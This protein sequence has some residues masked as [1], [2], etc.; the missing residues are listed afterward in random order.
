MLAG[1]FRLSAFEWVA[2]AAA[3]LVCPAGSPFGAE[4][5]A[6]SGAT[7]PAGSLFDRLDR[8]RDGVLQDVHWSFGLMGYLSTYALGNL[9]S[10]QLWEVIHRDIPDI[11]G[12]VRNAEFAPL[13]QWLN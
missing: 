13:L 6:G 7:A 11:E 10:A 2:L 12:K 1:M 8:N 5:G 4:A 9:V 3:L